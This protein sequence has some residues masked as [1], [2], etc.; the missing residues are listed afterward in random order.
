MGQAW[1]RTPIPKK[2]PTERAIKDVEQ[3]N[4]DTSEVLADVMV[5]SMDADMIIADLVD[6][7]AALEAEKE[8]E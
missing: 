8:A 6:R 3:A 7:V 5:S 4:L 2:K 1:R